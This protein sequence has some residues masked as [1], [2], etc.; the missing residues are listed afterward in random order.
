MNIY[1]KR[2]KS[3]ETTIKI[4]SIIRLCG[5]TI[6]A[7][8]WASSYTFPSNLMKIYNESSRLIP[9][10]LGFALD[11]YLTVNWL[12]S[13]KLCKL[14]MILYIF[15]SIF[16]YHIYSIDFGN[17]DSGDAWSVL[18][19]VIVAGFIWIL[20]WNLFIICKIGN[21]DLA[22]AEAEQRY[23]KKKAEKEREENM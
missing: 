5:I 21:N 14:H 20:G 11:I 7:L 2:V 22:K 23:W 17:L 4:A 15:L 3:A 13:P 18:A 12:K 8:M 6:L 1:D 16:F 10:I 19:S 9:V